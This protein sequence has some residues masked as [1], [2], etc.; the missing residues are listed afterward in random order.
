MTSPQ[1]TRLALWHLLAVLAL[2][3][4]CSLAGCDPTGLYAK[5]C[6]ETCARHGAKWLNCSHTTWSEC[7]CVFPLPDVH[8]PDGGR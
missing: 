4:V 2:V 5:V 1:A 7:A 3:F 6:S 8:A